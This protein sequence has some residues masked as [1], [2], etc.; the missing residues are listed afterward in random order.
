MTAIM[1]PWQGELEHRSLFSTCLLNLPIVRFMSQCKRIFGD[2][3]SLVQNFIQI[4]QRVKNFPI[5]PIVKVGQF[6]QW[7]SIGKFFICCR[8]QLK[9]RL[10]VRL[11]RCNKRD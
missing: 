8:I 6:L 4:R 11:K 2:I 9:V 7:V 3:I 5:D 1:F 10:R